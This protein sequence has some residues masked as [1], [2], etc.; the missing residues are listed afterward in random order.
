ML[1]EV[2]MALAGHPGHLVTLNRSSMRVSPALGLL[3]PAEAAL[4]DALLVLGHDCHTVQE[5][6]K[7]HRS[8]KM[9]N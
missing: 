5:F 9:G 2:I 1:H 4:V 8:G 3:H 6:V 7:E